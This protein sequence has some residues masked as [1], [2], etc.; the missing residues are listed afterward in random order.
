MRV[1]MVQRLDDQVSIVGNLNYYHVISYDV[2]PYILLDLIG[3]L[4]TPS[5]SLLLVF[6]A[7]SCHRRLGPRFTTF[8]TD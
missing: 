2:I 5:S 1:V 3:L 6:L 4:K 7:L 8:L